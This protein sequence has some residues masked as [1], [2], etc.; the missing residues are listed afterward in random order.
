MNRI[1][2]HPILDVKEKKEIVFYFEGNPLKAYEEEVISS[3]LFANGIK[4]FSYHKK[5]TAPQ[6]IFCANGQCAQC[7]VV[8]DGRV[9]KA[10]VSKVKESM[11]IETLKGAAKINLKEETS[12]NYS[13]IEEIDTDVLIIGGGPSG[14]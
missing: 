12:F 3:A 5:D 8:A 10:C 7:S 13:S 9:V 6:G 1:K 11:K 4:I 2:N 14:M